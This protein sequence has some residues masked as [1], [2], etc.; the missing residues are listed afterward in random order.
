M[1]DQTNII[2]GPKS[3]KPPRAEHGF[4]LEVKDVG[5]LLGYL[6][7]TEAIWSIAGASSGYANLVYI[8][9]DVYPSIE[10][11]EELSPSDLLIPPL[12]TNNLAW[13]R[14]YFQQIPNETVVKFPPSLPVHGFLHL[15]TGQTY[16]ENG[17]VIDS[18]PADSGEFVLQSYLTID[19]RISDAL[20]IQRAA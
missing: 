14:G 2:P 8:Y 9:S 7:S 16:D 4:F 17:K 18:A 10:A 12:L 20:G 15:R 6:V 1:A 13:S 11:V 5:F 3:R 19:D